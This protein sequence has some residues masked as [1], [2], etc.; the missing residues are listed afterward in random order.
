MNKVELLGRTTADV[1]LQKSK[2]GKEY[3]R[4]TLAVQRKL[5]KEKTDFLG[6]VKQH[7]KQLILA[8]ISISVVIGIILGVKNKDVLEDL[9]ATLKK[10]AKSEGKPH[11][12]NAFHP[13]FFHIFYF[14]IL[15]KS[16]KI[17]SKTPLFVN[18]YI[19]LLSFLSPMLCL[20]L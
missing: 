5:D 3:A 15:S 20:Y 7:K 6:W 14:P 1:E 18:N 4:F 12:I 17:L 2:D 19:P 11:F 9:W 8:G 16:T 13:R 10:S